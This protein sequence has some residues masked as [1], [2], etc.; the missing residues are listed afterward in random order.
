MATQNLIQTTQENLKRGTAPATV[1]QQTA[2]A[3]GPS[4]YP[5]QALKKYFP[6]VNW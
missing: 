6:G 1:F 5:C 4:G 3:G 2:T